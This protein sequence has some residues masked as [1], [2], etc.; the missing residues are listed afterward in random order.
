MTPMGSRSGMRR[1]RLS[2]CRSRP[3]SGPDA[4]QR[5]RDAQHLL[6]AE[7]LRQGVGDPV[8]GVWRLPGD[9]AQGATVV[10][11]LVVAAAHA[12]LLVGVVED[13]RRHPRRALDAVELAEAGCLDD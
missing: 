8:D 13:R 12:P 6:V 3:G 7:A 9:D 2:G 4:A 5:P 10:E 1:G 11:E